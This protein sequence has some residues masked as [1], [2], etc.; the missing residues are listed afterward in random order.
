[1]QR[2]DM[3]VEFVGGLRV[4]DA[5]DRRDREDGARR[6]GQQGHRAAP[7][8]PRAAGGRAVRRRRAAVPRRR[9]RPAPAART[10]ASSGASSA[11]TSA[12]S[13]H[14]AQD[15]I[16][17]IASVGADRDG[18]LLQ[19]QRRR[20]RRRRRA[21]AGRLQ[22][23][24][25]HR[26]RRLA[27]RPGRPGVGD[28]RG[29][30]RRGRGGAA[31][32]SPAACGRSSQACVDAIHG[33]V[34]LAHIVDGRVP[35]SLLL[36]LFTDAGI[37]TKIRRRE[38]SRAQALERARRPHLRALAGRV[39]ARRGRAAVGRRR[40]R[41]PRLPQP[42][43][44]SQRSA[45]ATRGRRGDAGAGGAADA[46]RATSS[47]P[48]RGCALAERL[49]DALAGRQGR[50]SPTPA[51]RPTRP[52]SSSRAR[53]G[54]A[55]AIV[56]LHRGFHGRTYGA[57]S[58]TPQETKQAPFAPL[59]PGLRRRRADRR[60]A[61]RGAVDERHRGASCSSRSRARA[62]CT[63]STDEL[64]QAA[65]AACDEHGA[66]LIFDEVQMR[67]GAHGHAVGLRAATASC[68]TLMTLAKALGG[69]LPIGALVIGA[70]SSADVF[71][72]G[73]HGSTFAGSP[74]VSAAATRR[75]TCSTTRRCWRAS[76]AGRAARRRAA[77]AP[78]RDRG[79]RARA[80]ARRRGR[81]RRALVRQA[82]AGGA[83][84]R[85]QRD[86]PAT[87]R[88]MP[89]LVVSEEEITEALR[90]LA[91]LAGDDHRRAAQVEVLARAHAEALGDAL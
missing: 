10:S 77:R 6:Q 16:P 37:G 57:L 44:R 62:A 18:Q 52:R 34:G 66:L 81:L 33:G 50:T 13:T 7:E 12:C 69:G 28:P 30:R 42:A 48:S 71:E 2:L 29:P 49:T 63:R 23:H 76:R 39:R 15:Y 35:H 5:R 86:R 72:P 27:A 79:A 85:A 88:F 31:R 84:A 32:A 41:V 17:V 56:S 65:R 22:G 11:S 25:P 4:T 90:R 54:R 53:R 1:M 80:D 83:G 47:T 60:G 74:L 82:R 46:R 64:L 75:S 40:Q 51:P 45:T 36:E 19:R 61:R 68:P 70:A 21:R 58:A 87:V 73:D 67:P 26:R 91:A 38:P 89:P 55:G 9:A 14:I 20:G 8:P 59:V 24:V 43:S 78:G 3:P